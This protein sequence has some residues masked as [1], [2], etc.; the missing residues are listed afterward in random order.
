[1]VAMAQ[2][3]INWRNTHTHVNRTHSLTHLQCSYNHVVRSAST[4]IAEFGIKF[5]LKVPEREGANRSTWRKPHIYRRK[6][7]VPDGNRTLTFQHCS[8]GLERAPRLTH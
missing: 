8:L 7:N 3:A 5:Y 6:S 2:S 1:M 4:A